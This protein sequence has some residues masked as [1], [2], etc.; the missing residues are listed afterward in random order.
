VRGILEEAGIDNAAREAEW[1]LE[2]ATSKQSSEMIAASDQ[3]ISEMTAHR[4]LKLASRRAAGEP[5]QYLTGV[6][7]F[8]YLQLKVGPGVFIPRPETELVAARA[9]SR[10]PDGGSLVD[11]GTGSG[12][13]A[14]AVATERPQARVWATERSPIAMEWARRNRDELDAA[15]T[16]IRGD[17][18]EGLPADLEGALD[19]VVSN[20]PYVAD[21]DAHL[22]GEDVRNHEPHEALFAGLEGLL[23]VEVIASEARRWLRDGGWLVMEIGYD[24]AK[25][26]ADLLARLDYS[27]VDVS[28]DLA[29]KDRIVE[30][31]WPG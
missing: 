1:L 18:F 24:Q 30:A 4:A 19:V 10:L 12:A 27:D 9:M 20:P 26:V 21:T 6:A 15:V 31:R 22:L 8:R 13:I 28:Q 16:L 25:K 3:G 14:L 29:H 2:A 5:L 7:G 17:L 23:L 11:I